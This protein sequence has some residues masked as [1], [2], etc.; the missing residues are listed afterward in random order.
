M[1]EAAR[2]LGVISAVLL[3]A[4]IAAWVRLLRGPTLQR[5]DGRIGPDSGQAQVASQLL[6]LA[7]GLSAVAAVLAVAGWTV[8]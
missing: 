2:V 5:L 8:T 1:L 4:A 6:M 7:A 3:V